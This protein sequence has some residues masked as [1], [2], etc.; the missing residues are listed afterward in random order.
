M[1]HPTPEPEA[2]PGTIFAVW[3]RDSLS[4]GAASKITRYYAK[5]SSA[6]AY[7][8]ACKDKGYSYDTSYNVEEV[9]VLP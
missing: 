2:T 4:L 5:R 1:N 8:T 3:E 6:E 9:T 7:V